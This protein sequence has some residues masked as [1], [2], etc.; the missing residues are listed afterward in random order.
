MKVIAHWADKLTAWYW[1]A[2]ADQTILST[3]GQKTLEKGKIYQ[4][5]FRQGVTIQNIFHK[6]IKN[7]LP[8]KNKQNKKFKLMINSEANKPTDNTYIIKKYAQSLYICIH[9][10]VDNFK[11]F[12]Y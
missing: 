10:H 11:S 6:T 2:S 3:N 5:Y 4:A 1:E 7:Y 8:I 9:V 12:F